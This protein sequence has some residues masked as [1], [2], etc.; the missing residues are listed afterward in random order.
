M[1]ASPTLGVCS[2]TP[3]AL[4][5]SY[6]S[7]SSISVSRFPIKTFAPTSKFLVFEAAWEGKL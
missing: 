4:K 7:F 1:I 5:M 2:I 3:N 6:N